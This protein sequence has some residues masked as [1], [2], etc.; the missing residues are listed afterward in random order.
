[1]HAGT[2][3]AVY[4]QVTLAAGWRPFVLRTTTLKYFY[5]EY[6]SLLHMF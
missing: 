5:F 6:P 4:E 3:I 2:G 1:M